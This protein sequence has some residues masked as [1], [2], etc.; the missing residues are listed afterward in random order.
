MLP[1]VREYMVPVD[2]ATWRVDQDND[3]RWVI[4]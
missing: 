2:M 1:L 3:V 4:L